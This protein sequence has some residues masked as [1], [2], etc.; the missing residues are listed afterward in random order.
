MDHAA[1]DFYFLVLFLLA[2]CPRRPRQVTNFATQFMKVEADNA[3][4]RR[5]LS[6][7][8]GA[9]NKL[10]EEAW[11]ANEDLKQELDQVKGELAKVKEAYELKKKEETAAKKA[12]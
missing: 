3:Q 5:E 7:R 10:V 12:L 11:Q 9:A 6:E 8:V 2:A 1:S 4:L